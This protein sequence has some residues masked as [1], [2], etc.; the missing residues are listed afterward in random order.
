MYVYMYV[1]D[2]CEYQAYIEMPVA[3][4]RIIPRDQSAFIVPPFANYQIASPWYLVLAL[5]PCLMYIP[6]TYYIIT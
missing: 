6:S 1:S 5:S 2:Q 4:L 3:T